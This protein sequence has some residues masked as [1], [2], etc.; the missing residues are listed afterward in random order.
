MMTALLL[1][2]LAGGLAGAGGAVLAAACQH[3]AR[4]L[5]NRI[6]VA[7]GEPAV[8]DVVWRPP[9][10]PLGVMGLVAGAVAGAITSSPRV[11]AAAG[12]ALPAVL[13][14]TSLGILL[15]ARRR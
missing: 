13:A 6:V 1:G 7:R 12:A 15:Q 8:K 11:A 5:R 2:A 4:L 9:W 14:A 10:A 3:G